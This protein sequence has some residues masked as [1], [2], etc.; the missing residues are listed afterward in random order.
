MSAPGPLSSIRLPGWSCVRKHEY[1]QVRGALGAGAQKEATDVSLAGILRDPE[2]SSEITPGR[3]IENLRDDVTL[4]PGK[5]V[6]QT[7]S[8]ECLG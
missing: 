8:I 5:P 1:W 4:A 3:S 6:L 7:E 2:R